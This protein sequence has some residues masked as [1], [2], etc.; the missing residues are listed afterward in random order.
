M[1]Q[2]NASRRDLTHDWEIPKPIG[3]VIFSNEKYKRSFHLY[4][5]GEV[6]VETYFIYTEFEFEKD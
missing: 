3:E 2:I 5:N 4:K 6:S 1:D